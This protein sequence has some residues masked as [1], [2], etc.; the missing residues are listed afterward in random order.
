MGH[1]F[2][3]D[4]VLRVLAEAKKGSHLHWLM[5]A[6]TFIHGLRA[7]EVVGRKTQRTNRKTKVVTHGRHSGLTPANVI[8]T[9]LKV[10]RLKNSN[11][12]EDELLEHKNPLLNVRQA[13]LDLCL[14][15]PRN[16]RLFPITQRTFQRLMHKYGEAAGLPELYCIPHTLK[17]SIIDYLRKTMELEELQERSGHK[18]LDSLRIYLHPKKAETDAMVR[19]A[20]GAAGL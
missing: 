19:S 20:L 2:E 1:S 6:L 10:K 14:I 18:S 11:P 16:Q 12:V 9:T 13:V 7:G 5:F 4:E 17:H 8:G 15:T 3:I